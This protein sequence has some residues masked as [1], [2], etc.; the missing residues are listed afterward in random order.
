MQRGL[1]RAGD[2]Q[3]FP[4]NRFF[5]GQVEH[6]LHVLAENADILRKRTRLNHPSGHII[7]QNELIARGIEIAQPENRHFRREFRFEQ[8]DHILVFLFDGD[9]SLFG[10]DRFAYFIQSP[11][12]IIGKRFQKFFIF[13]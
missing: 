1:D 4:G 11:H 13:M 6:R 3:I 7:D 8:S 12:D 2:G 9:K 10:S 5:P